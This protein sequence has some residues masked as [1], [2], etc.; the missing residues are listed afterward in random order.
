MTFGPE[1]TV[2]AALFDKLVNA[3]LVVATASE[4]SQDRR[5][6]WLS[7]GV[8][9]ADGETVTCYLAEGITKK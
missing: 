9:S 7:Y 2:S 4:L 6:H 1:I 5:R 3:G 8:V